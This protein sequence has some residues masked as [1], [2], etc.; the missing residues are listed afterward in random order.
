MPKNNQPAKALEDETSTEEENTNVYSRQLI[1]CRDTGSANG[2]MVKVTA[3]WSP[4][5]NETTKQDIREHVDHTMDWIAS[6][7]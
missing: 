5:L 2:I 6:L 4:V 7:F 1:L 3:E